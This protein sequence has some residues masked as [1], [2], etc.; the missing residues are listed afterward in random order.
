MTDFNLN[1]L[2]SLTT[3]LGKEVLA[4]AAAEHPKP[5][6]FLAVYQRLEKLYPR[7]LARR[8]VEQVILREKAREKFE[9][10]S[11]MFFEKDA[12][13][14]ASNGIIARHRAR[15]FAGPS[16]LF[17]FGCGIGADSLVLAETHE[18]V[19][20]DW[21]R[22]RLALLYMNAIALH[23]NQRIHPIAMDLTRVGLKL[24]ANAAGFADPARRSGG[25]RYRT[26]E[27]YSPPLAILLE[28]GSNLRGMGVKVSPAINLQDVEQYPCEVEFISLN[29]DLKEAV[30]W[31]GEYRCA[32]IRASLLPAGYELVDLPNPDLPISQPRSILYEPDPAVIRAG[33]V[34]GLGAE[35]GLCQLD[36]TT[37]FLTGDTYH[38]NPYTKAFQVLDS[39]PFRLKTLRKLLREREI[40]NLTVKKRGS[41]VDV[42]DLRQRLRL[43][44]EQTGTLVLTRV[45]GR[46]MMLLV[47]PMGAEPQLEAGQNH[48]TKVG[49]S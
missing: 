16:L 47:E 35:L 17:D 28:V 46:P 44:G 15:R 41:A 2:N 29:G 38:S 27:S 11:E 12:L 31:F 24:P 37:A 23:L 32:G 13:E 43:S 34:R 20:I 19:A 7:Q 3:D 18:V 22:H 14:Q 1:S 5:A 10:A 25:K 33:M 39:R 4:A 36:P 21:D 9:R 40:G 8:A 49:R 26:P 45:S 42:D 48:G 6:D 30:L